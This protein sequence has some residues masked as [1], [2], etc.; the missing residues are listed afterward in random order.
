MLRRPQAP[1]DQSQ[2]HQDADN[3]TRMCGCGPTSQE[4]PVYS[5]MNSVTKWNLVEYSHRHPALDF[6]YVCSIVGDL[7]VLKDRVSRQTPNT[8]K[9]L[10][11]CVAVKMVKL[12]RQFAERANHDVA[13]SHISQID[14]TIFKTSNS[15]VAGTLYAHPSCNAQVSFMMRTAWHTQHVKYTIMVGNVSFTSAQNGWSCATSLQQVIECWERKS[16]TTSFQCW[17]QVSPRANSSW[18][19]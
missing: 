10:Y 14:L 17:N 1:A 15:R 2:L 18:C 13:V 19:L 7:S 16:S 9:E 12:N 5:Q 6:Q 3:Y 4:F 11:I 8:C